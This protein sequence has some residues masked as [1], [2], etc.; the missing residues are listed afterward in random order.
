MRGQAWEGGVSHC[1]CHPSPHLLVSLVFFF[2]IAHAPKPLARTNTSLGYRNQLNER[3]V[4]PRGFNIKPGMRCEKWLSSKIPLYV[5]V[6]MYQS[7]TDLAM[8]LRPAWTWI[9]FKPLVFKLKLF[10][11]PINLPRHR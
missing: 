6:H 5:F 11:H 9:L 10:L 1:H 3:R 2:S 8:T 4:Y 7:R